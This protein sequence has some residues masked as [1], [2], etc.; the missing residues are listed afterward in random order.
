MQTRFQKNQLDQILVG[1]WPPHPKFGKSPTFGGVN[2]DRPSPWASPWGTIRTMHHV[3]AHATHRFFN[4]ASLAC[5]KNKNV[6]HITAARPRNKFKPD[7]KWARSEK[8]H[9]LCACA[10]LVLAVARLY[11]GPQSLPTRSTHGESNAGPL[12][13]TYAY[14]TD[15]QLTPRH[16]LVKSLDSTS[17]KL[18]GMQGVAARGPL[19]HIHGVPY[20]RHGQ[21]LGFSRPSPT[22]GKNVRFQSLAET[23]IRGKLWC[24]CHVAFGLGSCQCHQTVPSSEQTRDLRRNDPRPYQQHGHEAHSAFCMRLGLVDDLRGRWRNGVSSKQLPL[25]MGI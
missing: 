17:V 2:Q 25:V 12:H 19:L 4:N 23:C 10:V 14:Y 20:C 24:D 1:R 21:V 22:E 7:L 3:T 11:L 9:L 15:P 5:Q 8:Q 18:M 13:D 16:S 6:S